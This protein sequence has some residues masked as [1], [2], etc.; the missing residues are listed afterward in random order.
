MVLKRTALCFWTT[1]PVVSDSSLSIV[2]YD[3]FHMTALILELAKNNVITFNCTELYCNA[4]HAQECVILSGQRI[5][6]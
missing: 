3:C 4:Q 1:L 5:L 6:V 2:T